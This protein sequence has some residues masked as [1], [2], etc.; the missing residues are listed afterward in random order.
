MSKLQR[1]EQNSLKYLEEYPNKGVTCITTFTLLQ[2]N[3][4]LVH[5]GFLKWDV[6]STVRFFLN[7]NISS[8]SLK[9]DCN[10]VLIY[11]IFGYPN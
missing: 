11:G 6:C 7:S 3:P 8:V 2:Y 4:S 5:C 9:N 1:T 10:F